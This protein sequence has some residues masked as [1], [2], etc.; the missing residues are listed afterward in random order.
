MVLEAAPVRFMTYNVRSCVGTDGCYDP[1]RVAQVIE[2]AAPDVVALQEV[3]VGLDR[4][5]GHD[6][7]E[8][9]AERLGMRSHFTCARN[10]GDG[11]YGNAILSRW[12]SELYAEA[13]LPTHGGE[14]RAVQCVR[15]RHDGGFVELLNTHL[16][17]HLIERLTQVKVLLGSEWILRAD[18]GG[19]LIVCGDFNSGPLSPVYRRITAHLI[20]AQRATRHSV[21]A[22]WPSLLPFLRIDHVFASPS[23]E[24]RRCE[25]LRD[26]LARR[27]SDHLPIVVDVVLPS[28][29][30][31]RPESS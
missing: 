21:R 16:S 31:T 18:R 17:I 5:S 25:V 1:E 28:E 2:R 7:A 27:A 15:V 20:D 24:V 4:T 3:D 29:A 13:C 19:P 9:L 6:Q 8:W 22:T 12:P 11:Q 14:V 30:H 23:L 26:K 10:S